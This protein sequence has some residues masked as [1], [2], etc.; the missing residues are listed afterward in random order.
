MSRHLVDVV[1]PCH[2]EEALLPSCLQGLLW[3]GSGFD[4]RV[5][6]V[7]NGCDDA[8]ADTLRSFGDK[9]AEFGIALLVLEIAEANKS[10]ALNEGLK[11]V[12]S[13]S[14]VVFLDG[15][16]VLL[17]DTLQSLADELERT[18]GPRMASPRA[19][20]VRPRS[21]L[22]R[23]YF[24]VWRELPSVENDTVGAG[25]YA[26]N[27]AGMKR[28]GSFPDVVAD[29]AFVRSLF[30]PEERT[31]CAA[32]GFVL[33]YPEGHE[34]VS[35]ARR[36][37]AGN[38]QLD[39]IERG[40]SPAG[41]W[42]GN[43]GGVALR[44]RLWASLPAFAL[45][46]VAIRAGAV[47]RRVRW[48]SARELRQGQSN[49]DLLPDTPSI[50]VIIVTYNSAAHIEECIGSLQSRLSRLNITV[51]DNASIDGTVDRV[52]GVRIV[53]NDTN[54]G[55][56]AAVNDVASQGE[57]DY[58]MLVN[59][60]TRV[61]PT[62]IDQLIA[63][64]RLSNAC[65]IGGRTHHVDGSLDYSCCLASPSLWHAVAFGLGLSS[66]PV[67][68]P[69]ALG[70]WE[71][72]DIRTVPALTGSL[73]LISR[74]L[75]R[76]LGG[77]DETFFVYGEDVDLCLRARRLGVEPS[78]APTASYMH[79]GGASSD[80][81]TRLVLILTGKATLYRKHLPTV[82]GRLACGALTLGVAL[83]AVAE[84]S[85][86]RRSRWGQVWRRRTEWQHGWKTAVRTGID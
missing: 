22:A 43:L 63:T 46:T 82:R 40:S 24:A 42:T 17:P 85:L 8:T 13:D 41:T 19:V 44:P 61:E 27:A 75:W 30:A 26:V 59:P 83:R 49:R 38:T 73:L 15:D 72:D 37:R 53:R 60:D 64:A 39:A 29:D 21:R 18:T 1:I 33:R 48:E 35:V 69:D 14:A 67:I 28:V 84:R 16:T 71:R 51:V 32:G 52:A 74:Q 7:A 45:V 5:V 9:F 62:T 54:V 86:R 6:A 10:R 55:F 36:W 65:L 47:R 68:D 20:G 50:G 25:C 12:R 2:N 4:L 58:I 76:S 57:S 78:F 80:S 70:G 66:L 23:G 56:A 31:V 34:M 3:Q 11:H 77:F 81:A 79:I